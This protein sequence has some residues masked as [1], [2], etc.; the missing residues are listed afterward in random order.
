MRMASGN[1]EKPYLR[2]IDLK[3][4]LAI[5]PIAAAMM[6]AVR[7]ID[8]DDK[9]PAFAGVHKALADQFG[10]RLVAPHKDRLFK[11]IMRK[12]EYVSDRYLTEQGIL[13]AI[14]QVDRSL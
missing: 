3:A 10:R 13:D 5:E 2:F 6:R 14:R 1:A 8:V 11:P 9:S 12:I 7:I 4:Q